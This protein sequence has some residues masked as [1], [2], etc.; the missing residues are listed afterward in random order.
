[1][2]WE[3]FLWVQAENGADSLVREQVNRPV[4]TQSD[5]PEPDHQEERTG[6]RGHQQE[7]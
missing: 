4:G 5:V 7:S 1:M 3:L 6:H 2:I